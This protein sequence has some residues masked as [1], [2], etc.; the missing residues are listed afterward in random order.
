MRR[1]T[2]LAA[3]SLC[4]FCLLA[5]AAHADTL[6]LTGATGGAVDGVDIYPYVFTVT[7]AG[8]TTSNFILSCL[9]FN[10][11]ISFGETWIVNDYNVLNIPAS[12]MQGF[13]QQQFR[14]DA[15][16]YN[17][18]AGASGNATLTGELQ[19]AIWSVMDPGDINSGSGYNGAG[20][21]DATAQALASTALANALSTPASQF[22][23]DWVFLP[24]LTN[25]T[26]WTYGTPQI[27]MTDPPPAAITPEPS[28]LLLLGTG[29]VGAGMAMAF[30]AGRL[31]Q[32]EPVPVPDEVTS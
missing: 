8:G 26:G 17:Q 20:A 18:Y 6:T 30:A 22:G 15:L 27:F 7:G 29:L 4:L 19:F 1:K 11:E 24:D 32:R 13:T 5:G 23:S 9:N 25:T 14:A 12:G 16:L 10:R 21:F 3:L 28:S 31:K 2:C